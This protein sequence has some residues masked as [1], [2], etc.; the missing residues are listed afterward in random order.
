MV[1]Y[2][3]PLIGG[4]TDFIFAP[5]HGL[6]IYLAYKT[7]L[8][9]VFGALEEILPFVDFIPSATIIHFIKAREEKKSK[10]LLVKH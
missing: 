7:R 10:A 5:I 8:G 9:A 1:S 3:I 2:F 6:W 4:L